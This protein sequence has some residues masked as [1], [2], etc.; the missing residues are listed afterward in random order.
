[1]HSA[2]VPT[3]FLQRTAEESSGNTYLLWGEQVEGVCGTPW[4][5]LKA[6]TGLIYFVQLTLCLT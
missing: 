4:D 5:S 2:V 6:L 1:M 3:V